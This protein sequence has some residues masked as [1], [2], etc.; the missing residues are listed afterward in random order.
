M[1]LRIKRSILRYLLHMFLGFIDTLMYGFSST[2]VTIYCYFGL[3][4]NDNTWDV[5]SC[6]N[7]C[8]SNL[9]EMQIITFIQSGFHVYPSWNIFTKS[10]QLGKISSDWNHAN[11]TLV[12]K[13][14]DKHRHGNYRPISLTCIS[15]KLLEQWTKV[16]IKWIAKH[17]HGT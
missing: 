6:C 10:I 3:K 2:G 1:F 15:Y 8:S 12:F 4:F 16:V 7:M 5:S 14:G 13:K 9:Y 11:V 17:F